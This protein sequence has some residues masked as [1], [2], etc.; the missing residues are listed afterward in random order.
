MIGSYASLGTHR[1]RGRRRSY[2]NLLRF[3]LGL[4]AVAMVGGY[5]YQVG[6]SANQAWTDRIEA[7]LQ[8]V[9]EANLDLRDE[10]AQTALSASNSQ[11][12][13]EALQR[14]YRAEV[15]DGELAELVGQVERQLHAGVA[16]DRLAFLIDAAGQDRGCAEA[17]VTKRFRP[18]TPI[19]PGP[20]SAVRF[21]ERVTV[22]A[23]AASAID[24]DGQPEAW[25]DPAL[26]VQLV[27]R[28]LDGRVL[29]VAG[30]LPLHHDMLVD[31]LEYRFSAIAGPTSFVEITAQACPFS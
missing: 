27:F 8:R 25:F 24:A 30:T 17:P 2:W 9:Q 21:D 31:G 26:P 3:L 19:S 13:L 11:T 14:R 20:A 16:R 1:R 29:E 7:D 23:T 5:G 12:A 28:T 4:V 18:R 10:L 6:V 22:S 15:P